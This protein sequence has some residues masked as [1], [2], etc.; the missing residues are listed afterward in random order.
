MS[1]R[2]EALPEANQ[3]LSHLCKIINNVF[4]GGFLQEFQVTRKH[5]VALQFTY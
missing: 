3:H 2:A 5:H 1:L 4:A